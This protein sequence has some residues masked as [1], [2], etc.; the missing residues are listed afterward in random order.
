MMRWVEVLKIDSDGQTWYLHVVSP[1]SITIYLVSQ[2]IRTSS[3]H[4]LKGN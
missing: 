4:S 1:G 2:H 3:V